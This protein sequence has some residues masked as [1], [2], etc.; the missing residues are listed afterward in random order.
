MG[1]RD[2]LIDQLHFQEGLLPMKYLGLPLISSRL[3]ISNCQPLLLKLDQRIKGWKGMALSYAGRVIIKSV[4]TAL[5]IYWVSTV[6]L[7]KGIIQE[8]EKWLRTFL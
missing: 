8:I 6:I 1:I 5:N 4:L 2:L 7:P 3:T